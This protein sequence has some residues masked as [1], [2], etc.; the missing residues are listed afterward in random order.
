MK[1]IVSLILAFILVLSLSVPAFAV[2]NL[3]ASEDEPS[4]D[5]DGSRAEQTVWFFRDNNGIL[6]KR[7]W[8]LTYRK[9]LTDWIPCGV[10]VDP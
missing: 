3:P 1:K 6:E 8:S 2:T 5:A 7:L 10:A 4:A 9:W